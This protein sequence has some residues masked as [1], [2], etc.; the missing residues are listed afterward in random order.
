M[1]QSV[2]L[3]AVCKLLFLSSI[4]IC[5]DS[6]VNL[7]KLPNKSS[8]K[9][10]A[11]KCVLSDLSW[12]SLTKFK[13]LGGKAKS[14][15]WRKSVIVADSNVQL[16]A[17][18][19]SIGSGSETP[20]SPAPSCVGSPKDSQSGSLIDP[21]LAFTKVLTADFQLAFD[22]LDLNDNL[23]PIYCEAV[24]H[25]MLPCLAVD[26]ISERLEANTN[27]L[28]SV[29]DKMNGLPPK[30]SDAVSSALSAP[31]TSCCDSLN[32]LVNNVAVQVQHLVS[33]VD[34]LKS[35]FASN[36]GSNKSIGAVST[37]LGDVSLSGSTQSEATRQR[38][39]SL[40]VI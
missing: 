29:A 16:G 20:A 22:K 11:I 15:N 35:T 31:L 17:F 21:V 3:E 1:L 5:V 2:H 6:Q 14:K 39:S 37:T 9:L 8:S 40:S 32:S 7:D 23:P 25:I 28:H 24:D 4:S 18:L 26:P 36:T 13:S 10:G 33:C 12:H 34:S 27:C 30:V 19:Q 38:Y